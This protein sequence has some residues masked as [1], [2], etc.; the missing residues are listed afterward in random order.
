MM[1]NFEP[2]TDEIRDRIVENSE[3]YHSYSPDYVLNE[4]YPKIRKQIMLERMMEAIESVKALTS[5]GQS[6]FGTLMMEMLETLA[7][8]TYK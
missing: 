5:D 1:F 7:K 3:R 8:E 2:T 4:L 6:M